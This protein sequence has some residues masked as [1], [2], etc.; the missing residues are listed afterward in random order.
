MTVA[1]IGLLG[2]AGINPACATTATGRENPDLT[3]TV[4]LTPDTALVGTTVTET[5]AVTNNT[6]SVL[7]AT[8]TRQLTYPTGQ[9]WT[10]SVFVALRPGQTLTQGQVYP[11]TSEYALGTY[12]L[13][14]SATNLH[15][16]STAAAT[17][18]RD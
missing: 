4:S 11:I 18:T 7:A 13:V 6:S 9:S 15:G 17:F 10:E 1:A 14:L 8:L 16:A 2:W 12:R 3:V 5:W